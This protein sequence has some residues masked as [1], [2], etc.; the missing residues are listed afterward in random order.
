[1]FR[2]FCP[3]GDLSS[4]QSCSWWLCGKTVCHVVHLWENL[5]NRPRQSRHSY[6]VN[7]SIHSLVL[8]L[9]CWMFLNCCCDTCVH[10]ILGSFGGATRTM[11]LSLLSSTN[12]ET[13]RRLQLW[14][15]EA[16]KKSMSMYSDRSKN[17][18]SFEKLACETGRMSMR[19]NL[20]WTMVGFYMKPGQ[21]A[22]QRE[23]L[24]TIP[25]RIWPAYM[26]SLC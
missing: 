26:R 25:I 17:S 11:F 7:I 2:N 6:V 14:H 13:R 10:M 12:P 18:T 19:R 9:S 1:M 3:L 8:T 22:V 15:Y 23:V 16:Q 24:T 21:V 20:A 4:W 5:I